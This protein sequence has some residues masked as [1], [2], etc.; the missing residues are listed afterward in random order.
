MIPV[1]QQLEIVRRG[2]AEIV[3]DDELASKLEKSLKE[4]R[5][6]RVKL[7]LDPTAPDIHL[8]WS[9]V[10]RKLRQFQDLGH[11]ACLII[12]DFTA[13]IGDP[14]GKSKTRKQLTSEEVRKNA[15]DYEEQLFK[16][17]D[18]EKTRF[19][20][21]SDWL[22]TMTF[23]DVIKLGAKYTLARMLE[24]EDFA[25]RFAGQQPISIHELLYPLCQGYDSVAIE[26]DI[27]MGGMDQKFN[28]LVGRDLQREYGQEPQVALMMPLLIGLD[29]VEKMSQSLGN[30]VGIMEP[31]NEIYGKL[32]SISDEMMEQ[33]FE[34]CTDIPM[35]EVQQVLSGHPKEAKQRLAREIVSLYHSVEDAAHAEAEFSRVFSQRDVPT[36]MDA[37]R[38][39]SEDLDGGKVS[40]LKLIRKA[41]FAPSNNEARRLVE[42]GGV[43]I[44]GMTVSDPYAQLAP[45]DGG[46]LKVGKRKFAR[47]SLG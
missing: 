33:Y 5:P 15:K 6:L 25:K 2:V 24:R 22:G 38:I 27:E 20:F 8:G 35:V 9:V 7:G 37:L 14:S 47:V 29:G 4:G 31:P 1:D 42:Q 26:A 44:D 19:F 36:E 17:L 40:I 21:N 30:Y 32:M 11:E 16:I 3:P 13:Q 28:N 43:S 41:G 39:T 46:V 45:P 10:L 34:L 18:P 12:G 23:A